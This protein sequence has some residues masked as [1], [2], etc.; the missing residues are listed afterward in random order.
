MG[1]Y[2]EL[3]LNLE[4]KSSIPDDALAVLRFL[5]N[6]DVEPATLPDHPFFKADRWS[7]IMRCSSYYFV[8]FSLSK[9]ES[10]VSVSSSH[11]LSTRSDL[12]NYGNEID[13]FV[14]WLMPYVDAYEGNFLGYKRY[15]EDEKP[16]LLYVGKDAKPDWRPA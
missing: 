1:M 16:T 7:M 8:P 10:P 3:V 11:Y 6:G 2:T 5:A 14:D 13:L 4:I 15:E 9:L 12:K